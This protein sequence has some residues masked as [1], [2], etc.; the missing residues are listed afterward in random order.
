MEE[1]GRF[2]K[3]WIC[4]VF[5]LCTVISCTTAVDTIYADQTI[6]D[7][8]TIVSADGTFELGFYGDC[9][10]TT[11][12]RYVGIWSKKGSCTHRI[13]NCDTPLTNTSGELSL[14]LQGRVVVRYSNGHV[15]W[16]S[17]KLSERKLVGQ[18][19]NNGNFIVREETS[20][21]LKKN[22]NPLCL[23]SERDQAHDDGPVDTWLMLVG[24]LFKENS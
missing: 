8:E 20:D 12:K 3:L 21:D 6:R 14:T 11:T 2:T 17:P 9:N 1:E 18:L 19:L 5:V 10:S 23:S 16:S 24:Y 22:P 4:I 13:F 7:G 15:I